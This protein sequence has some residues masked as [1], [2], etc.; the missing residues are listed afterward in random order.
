MADIATLQIQVETKDVAAAQAA[1]KSLGVEAKVTET[2]V[3]GLGEAAKKNR[4]A[5]RAMRGSVQQLGYQVQDIAVQLQAGTSAITVFTQ[6]GSQ[7]AA[8]FG[9]G[10][11]VIG[12]VIAIAGAIAGALIP[13]LIKGSEKA[14]DLIDKFVKMREELGYL[15]SAQ[16]EYLA[17]KL[18]EKEEEQENAIVK[19]VEAIQK[20]ERELLR[21]NSQL[22]KVPKQ[23]DN[24]KVLQDNISFAEQELKKLNSDLDVQAQAAGKTA[25]QIL[26]LKDGTFGLEKQQ[27]SA[28]EE[29]KNFVEKLE[30]EARALSLTKDQLREYNRE[31]RAEKIGQ[32][33]DPLMR[34]RAEDAAA[35]IKMEQDL[36]DEL[37]DIEKRKQEAIK[38][39]REQE[40]SSREQFRQEEKARLEEQRIV[41]QGLLS[42]EDNLLKNKTDKQKAGYRVAVNL[43]D[44]EKRT[45]AVNI[46]STSYEAAMKA[47]AAM[48]GIPIIGPALGAAAAATVIAAGVSFAAQSL[49]GRALGGQVR[50]GES[51]VVGERGP[52]ILTMGSTGRI[53]P[54]DKIQTS[55]TEVGNR[56]VNVSFNISTVDAAGFDTLLQSRRGQ[57]IG[58]INTAMNERGRPALA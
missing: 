28:A 56:N 46:V 38:R 37:D 52:E 47:Y 3:G 21:L 32:I 30:A 45:R 12:A 42:L 51:Y 1:L 48:A 31:K 29:T 23:A 13:S 8:L 11:A 26:R 53:T 14:E 34:Q 17:L 27:K 2:K 22:A 50:A 25:E 6:Q 49:A 9:P 39:T 36:A 55:Q 54:N 35:T 7:I 19:T 16:K 41:N 15:T 44:Q 58:I 10:G 18:A 5:F 24:Y 40:K 33:E 57:I 4:G 20:K 43:L